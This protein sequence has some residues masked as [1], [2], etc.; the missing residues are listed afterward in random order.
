MCAG[1]GVHESLEQGLQKCA[2]SAPLRIYTNASLSLNCQIYFR[3]DCNVSSSGQV[4]TSTI[5]LVAAT[6]K[7]PPLSHFKSVATS[8]LVSLLPNLTITLQSHTA[9]AG[10]ACSTAPACQ[11]LG[12]Y[13]VPPPT[14]D[15]CLQL[16][17]ALATLGHGKGRPK[18]P[19]QVPV[20]LACYSAWHQVVYSV[21]WAAAAF[22]VGGSEP[23]NS[24]LVLDPMARSVVTLTN[25]V[26]QAMPQLPVGGGDPPGRVLYEVQLQAQQICNHVAMSTT[27]L[28]PVA[29]VVWVLTFSSRGGFASPQIHLQP[30]CAEASLTAGGLC[31]LQLLQN[32]HETGTA[33]ATRDWQVLGPK[34][35]PPG[36]TQAGQ[37]AAAHALLRVAANEEPAQRWTSL[38]V[39]AYV[40]FG[41]LP[42]FEANYS[43][44][45]LCGSILYAPLLVSSAAHQH[46]RQ[47]WP[48]MEV[49]S[50]RVIIT[51]GLGGR[52]S[53]PLS[54][55]LL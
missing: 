9:A 4:A 51:G 41:A 15:S 32:A 33:L 14:V 47:G 5:H 24:F 7:I 50:G 37:C 8:T 45:S 55:A 13:L 29:L 20:A 39:A 52:V 3:G 53:L 30:G 11:T 6:A 28:L 36:L 17:A 1:D 43:D 49:A 25:L 34:T 26:A 48:E 10:L 46:S 12:G 23:Q 40:P 16:G 42:V 35:V 18:A 44:L 38:H 21:S 22:P 27:P 2:I 19:P 31:D 54:Q